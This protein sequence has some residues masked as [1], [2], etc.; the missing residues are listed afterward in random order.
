MR[1]RLFLAVI[2]NGAAET[3]SALAGLPVELYTIPVSRIVRCADEP[4]LKTLSARI[5]EF[6]W[7]MMTSANA[8]S[9]FFE[10][11]KFPLEDVAP[12]IACIGPDTAACVEKLGYNV[13]FIAADHRGD[14]FA[15]EF[16]DAYGDTSLSVLVPRPEKMGSHLIKILE[17]SGIAVSPIILYRTEPV[18]LDAMPDM[19]FDQ[20][21]L[22]A[23]LS[24]S[25]VR[26]FFMRY[27]IPEDTTVF[28]I[29]PT[30]AAAVTERG[31]NNVRISGD[32][33]RNG[34]V[35]VIRAFLDNEP[36]PKG[37]TV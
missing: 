3:G 8:A 27:S 14:A 16:V 26:H 13:D 33:S 6:D 34:L 36:L 4:A 37:D 20:S 12:K 23:F 18:S 24:P 22:F 25:G 10:A 2:E 15:K 35:D 29:G 11:V 28:A 30:T 21:D 5:R 9:I 1:R 19:D 17:Q 31:H 32:S 7:V